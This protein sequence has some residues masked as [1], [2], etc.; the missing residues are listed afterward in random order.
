MQSSIGKL[1][2]RA[3]VRTSSRSCSSISSRPSSSTTTPVIETP[4]VTTGDSQIDLAD[5]NVTLLFRIHN[6]I[7]DATLRGLK[8]DY[9]SLTHTTRRSVPHSDDFEATIVPRLRDNSADF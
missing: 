7:V 8:V 2:S 1:T 3:L 9:L 5:F 4:N 6:R